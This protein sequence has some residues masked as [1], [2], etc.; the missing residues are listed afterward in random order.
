[1]RYRVFGVDAASQQARE[2]ILIEAG[3]E[4][5]A[6]GRA[7]AQGMAVR[8]VIADPS[9][10]RADSPPHDNSATES[11][12]AAA[13][14]A[15]ELAALRRALLLVLL[16]IVAAFFLAVALVRTLWQAA[17]W[18]A[19]WLVGVLLAGG[20]AGL[21][22]WLSR[23][24]APLSVAWPIGLGVALATLSALYGA[25]AGWR[26]WWRKRS[27]NPLAQVLGLPPEAS[28]PGEKPA[29]FR[30]TVIL[31]HALA[32]A[33]L[34]TAGGLT[35][36]A[37]DWSFFSLAAWTAG[38][39]LGL[40]IEGAILGAVLSWRRPMLVPEAQTDHSLTGLLAGFAG[41]P[42]VSRLWV[43]GYAFD[44]AVPGAVAGTIVGLAAVLLAQVVC[45]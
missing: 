24:A 16:P 4:E 10:M 32:G 29:A 1:M 12:D 21:I 15:D 22:H 25:Q 19:V 14:P 42:R 30:R 9:P 20:V 8:A 34:G 41:D 36:W 6:R 43:L 28:S 27:L 45:P 40:G 38:G 11:V 37:T 18:T 7:V 2:P 17:T 33:V 44:R 23:D 26:W 13:A 31:V 39:A 35:G 3:S 5:E